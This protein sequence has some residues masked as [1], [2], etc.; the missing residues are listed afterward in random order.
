MKCEYCGN[1]LGIEDAVCPYCGKENKFAKKHQ[2]DMRNYSEQFDST[3]QEVLSN[4]KKFNSLTAR[5]TVI[6]VLVA[7][8][9]AMLVALGNSW[10]IRTYRE[11]RLIAKHIDEYKP[12][13][14]KLMEDR[15]YLGVYYYCQAKR[16]TYSDVMPEYYCVAGASRNY[17]S[18]YEY[19]G[20]LLDEDGFMDNSE[21]VQDI[22]EIFTR[23]HDYLTPGEYEKKKYYNEAN[24]AYIN[25]MYD[26]MEI[27]VKGYFNLTDEDMEGFWE[28]SEA[29]RQIL[30][31]EGYEKTRK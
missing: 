7:L 3:R 2:K 29:K 21:G 5:I 24:T 28:L 22:E 1:N 16:I 19:M 10:N 18:F 4:S 25:D 31:E 26:Q 13:L 8:I 27:M 9:A 17:N 11:E 12:V 20:Y 6:A 30:M 15:D 23:M 14:D